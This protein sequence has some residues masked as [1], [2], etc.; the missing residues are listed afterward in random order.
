MPDV[1]APMPPVTALPAQAVSGDRVSDLLSK[2]YSLPCSAAA[3]AFSQIAE[4]TSR[5]QLALNVL[6]PHLDPQVPTEVSFYLTTEFCTTV[7]DVWT[8]PAG[9]TNPYF[10]SFVCTLFAAPYHDQ[11]FPLGLALDVFEGEGKGHS[12]GK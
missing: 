1:M 9:T 7:A 11:S 8:C 10:V 3:Q 12:V 5:F 6:L 2:T 4:Q